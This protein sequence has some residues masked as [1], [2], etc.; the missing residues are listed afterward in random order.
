M[1]SKNDISSTNIIELKDKNPDQET[2]ISANKEL[3]QPDDKSQVEV[4]KNSILNLDNSNVKNVSSMLNEFGK[5]AINVR[6]L[7]LFYSNCLNDVLE[8][9][10]ETNKQFTQKISQQINPLQETIG[11]ISNSLSTLITPEFKVNLSKTASYF[12]EL[13]ETFAKAKNNPNSLLNWMNYSEKISE[14]IWTIP[15]DITSEELQELFTVVNSEKEFDKYMVKYFNKN[16]IIKLC[17][18]ITS[19]L[20]RKHKTMFKQIINAFDSKNYALANVGMLSIID[21]L[22]SHFLYNKGKSTRVDMF[23]PLIEEID[24][25]YNIFEV[26]PIMILNDNIKVIYEAVDFNRKIA[27]KTNKKVR[28]NPSQHDSIKYLV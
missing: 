3:K 10:V 4:N 11:K 28:R 2:I 14:Y 20:N 26:I 9:F 5:V 13:A 19:R 21:E 23:I 25:S 27:I 7:G 15:Y 18:E 6:K 1:H 8:S 24:N 17:G 22:C 16:K 12:T